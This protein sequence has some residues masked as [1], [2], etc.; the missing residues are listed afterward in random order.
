M[1]EYTALT[2]LIISLDHGIELFLYVEK[3]YAKVFLFLFFALIFF[4]L[5]HKFCQCTTGQ[6]SQGT[7]L[8]KDLIHLS[9][10]RN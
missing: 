3:K 1:L 9:L 8:G 7:G 10:T 4:P 2:M 6:F 5:N